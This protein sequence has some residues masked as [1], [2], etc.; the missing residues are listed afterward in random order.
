LALPFILNGFVSQGFDKWFGLDGEMLPSI[1]S[2][3]SLWLKPSVKV[4]SLSK[5]TNYSLFLFSRNRLG[6]FFRNWRLN[7]VLVFNNCCVSITSDNSRIVH[8]IGTIES[9]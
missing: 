7:L 5:G 2:P 9:F 6:S 8:E 3:G 4:D 1:D